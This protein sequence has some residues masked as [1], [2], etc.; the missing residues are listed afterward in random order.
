MYCRSIKLNHTENVHTSW[1]HKFLT[2][3]LQFP[4]T[5]YENEAK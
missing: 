5:N 2:H 3:L 4:N 1:S